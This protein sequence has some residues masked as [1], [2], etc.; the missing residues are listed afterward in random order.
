[1][2]RDQFRVYEVEFSIL[3]KPAVPISEILH[4][5][6]EFHRVPPDVLVGG[7]RKH[8]HAVPRHEAMWLARKLTGRSFPAIGRSFRRD[9]TTVI[10]GVKAIDERIAREA[11]E[12]DDI[13][14]LLQ[15]FPN[16][17]WH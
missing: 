9:H 11:V 7:S 8:C 2:H 5:V 17:V 1:M 12:G 16:V 15:K 3:D 10:S 14:V 13:I 6:S 4:H